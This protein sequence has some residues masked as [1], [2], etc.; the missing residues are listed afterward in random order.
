LA[1]NPEAKIYRPLWPKSGRILEPVRP[2]ATT[3][4]PK[5]VQGTDNYFINEINRI[6]GFFEKNGFVM[7][8]PSPNGYYVASQ[9]HNGLQFCIEHNTNRIWKFFWVNVSTEAWANIYD[10][11]WF[12][13]KG[14][15]LI[16][17]DGISRSRIVPQRNAIPTFRLYVEP[18]DQKNFEESLL[19]LAEKSKGIMGY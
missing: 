7:N 19:K 18:V 13:Q 17:K 11:N 9:M 5:P 14:Q 3:K 2:T 6:R 12:D 1:S 4:K 15:A 16:H 8:A 10:R